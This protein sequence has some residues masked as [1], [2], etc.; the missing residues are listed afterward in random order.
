M[1]PDPLII[2][3]IM[4]TDKNQ[5]LFLCQFLGN[6]LIIGPALRAHQNDARLRLGGTFPVNNSRISITIRVMLIIRFTGLFTFPS[7]QLQISGSG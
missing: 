2:T 5:M 3:F 1:F 7:R 4:A 6:L